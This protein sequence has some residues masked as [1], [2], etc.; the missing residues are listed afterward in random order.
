MP[1]TVFS[2]V[3]DVALPQDCF[4]CGLPARG[5]A[6]CAPCRDDLPRAQGGRCPVCALPA[7][8]GQRCGA[9]LR[10]PP[11]FDATRAAFEYGFPVDVLVQALKYRGR[12]AVARVLG[13]A[14]AGL[15]AADDGWQ[16]ADCVVPL[17]LHRRRLAERGFNQAVEIARP[18]ARAL[19]RPLL[20]D[21]V[22]R[23]RDTAAQE[24]LDRAAR[25]RNLRRAF[26]CTT[27]VEGLSLIVVDDVMTTGASLDAFARCLKA[28]GAR[29]V[30]NWVVARTPTP[31]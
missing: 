12:L 7:A 14:L 25:R 6:L 13:E 30:E 21:G 11:A 18:L 4:L 27:R 23:V 19:R 31:G 28:A 3:I 15:A 2:T 16:G 10:A 24:A 8:G 26:A 20:L 29:R 22:S 17:P 9:C 5:G 1:H